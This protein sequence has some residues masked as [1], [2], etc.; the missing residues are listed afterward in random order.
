MV[1]N[2]RNMVC[3]RCNMIVSQELIKLNLHPVHVELG[4]AEI[5][6]TLSAYQ[7]EEFNLAILGFGLELMVDRKSIL[8]EKIKKV[9]NEFISYQDEPVKVNLSSHLNQKLIYDYTYLANVFS[10]VEGLTIEHY[11][12]SQKIEKVKNLLFTGELSLKEIAYKLNY[13]STA[14]LSNQFKKIT[15]CTTSCF[16]E[17]QKK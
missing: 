10:Q 9:I 13:S 4:S 11:M 15:G 16:R 17:N 12:I 3:I 2:I 5:L 7:K 14:H 1:L 8:V 6:E